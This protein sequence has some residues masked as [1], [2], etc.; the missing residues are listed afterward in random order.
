MFQIISQHD[1]QARTDN[2]FIQG[3]EESKK[4]RKTREETSSSSS[5]TTE[6]V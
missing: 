1:N 4:G 3:G 6:F 2:R 5:S